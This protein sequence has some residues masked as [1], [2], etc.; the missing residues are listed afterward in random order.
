MKIQL[1]PL[2]QQ[3]L[4]NLIDFT[5][6]RGFTWQKSVLEDLSD[7]IKTSIEQNLEEGKDYMGRN[8]APLAPATI[9]RK[10]HSR[11]FEDTGVLKS[12]VMKRITGDNFDVYIDSRRN[13]IA[14]Y[15]QLGT[16]RMPARPF[17]GI[18]DDTLKQIDDYLTEKN[19]KQLFNI[20]L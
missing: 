6:L 5:T 1:D 10:G 17:F 9:K 15:L 16:R 14:N 2:S 18:S 8:V 13:E 12:S 7:I 20:K 4:D 19:L 11:V 3:N